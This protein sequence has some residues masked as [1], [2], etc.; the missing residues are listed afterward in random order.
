MIWH[1]NCPGCSRAIDVDWDWLT[2][3]VACPLCDHRHYPPTPGEN[4]FAYV[5]T[6]MWPAEMESAVLALRGTTCEVSGCFHEHDTLVHK[7]PISLGGKTS[8]DNLV[9]MC[10]HHA[11]MKGEQDY[12]KWISGLKPEDIRSEAP[13]VDVTFTLDEPVPPAEPELVTRPAGYIQ[14]IASKT[15]IPDTHPPGMHLV[16]AAPF[17]PGPMRRLVLHYTWKLEHDGS[18]SIILAAWPHSRPPDLSKGTDG[19]KCPRTFNEHR[20]KAGH[21][22]TARLELDLPQSSDEP[23]QL[24]GQLWV[25]AILLKS[26]GGRPVIEDYLLVGTG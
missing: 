25:A 17:L 26:E 20:G 22:D 7:K 5:G 24:A 3:E 12:D 10:A 13:T 21:N 18:C 14:T 1:Y 9:P 16:K 2:D 15:T 23:N 6:D 4:H 11:R 8:V 19:L